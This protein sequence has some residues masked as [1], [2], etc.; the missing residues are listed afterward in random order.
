MELRRFRF[1]IV[2]FAVT[3]AV[4]AGPSTV[5]G[6]LQTEHFIP[7]GQS[8]GVSNKLSAIGTIGA[9]DAER[10]VLTFA[11]PAGEVAVSL[12][13]RTRIWLDRSKL[14][15]TNLA[16]DAAALQPGR[17]AEVKFEDAERRQFADWIKIEVTRPE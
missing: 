12:T 4:L 8:P 9:Y 10:R 1:P 5:T 2:A 11:G 14:G 15:Q 16:G 3:F 6:Q 7:L 13:D 17:R